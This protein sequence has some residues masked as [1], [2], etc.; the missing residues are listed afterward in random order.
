MRLDFLSDDVVAEN[1]A[2]IL[3]VMDEFSRKCLMVDAKKVYKAKQ[4]ITALEN[5][6]ATY[7]KPEYILSLIHIF[8]ELSDGER[9]AL[10]IG[11]DV[12]TTEPNSLII[13]DEPERHLHRSIISPLR[14]V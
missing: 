2:R 6:V 12:L 4:L 3:N 5:L 7:G 9:N 10:L 11:S 1:K 14:C 8:A 13:L